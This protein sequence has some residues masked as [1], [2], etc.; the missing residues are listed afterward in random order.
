[1]SAFL[2]PIHYNVF[3]KIK[4][5][6]NILEELIDKFGNEILRTEIYETYGTLPQGELEDII[7][8]GN[9]HGW[10]QNQFIRT[11]KILSFLVNKLI[12]SGTNLDNIKL[13]YE[14]KGKEFKNLNTPIDV[15]NLFTSFYMDGMPC[16][17]A[18]TP[19]GFDEE[20]GSF[21]INEDLHKQYWEDDGKIYNELR[22]SW[23][24]GV[25]SEN[26]F[27]INL[28]GNI[29]EVTKCTD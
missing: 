15:F 5:Q 14:N 3:N 21:V 17:R 28:N 16:D 1:M 22:N 4:N 9:I 10:L 13:F 7:D 18:I 2:A 12:Q 24:K 19:L 8:H 26:N 11:E 23:L 20:K 25:S 29:Y 27:N 6:N